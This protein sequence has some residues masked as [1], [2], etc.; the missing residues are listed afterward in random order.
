MRDV[1]PARSSLVKKLLFVGSAAGV[2]A[3]IHYGLG[4]Q[5]L[6]AIGLLAGLAVA[7]WLG[8]RAFNRW[9]FRRML[10]S[11]RPDEVLQAWHDALST[12]PNADT[13]VPLLQATAL[14]A[15]GLTERAREALARAERG[16]AW[17]SAYEHRLMIETLLDS[18]EGER[19]LAVSK[20]EELRALP[21]PEVTSD[22]RERITLLRESV[23][24]VA[25]AF[26]HAAE[27][28]DA[29]LLWEAARRNAL[30]HWPLRYAAAVVCID[31]GMPEEAARLLDGAPTWPEESAFRS[32]HAELSALLE[33][34]TRG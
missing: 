7:V 24:A 26:A 10:Q 28:R 1:P 17:R 3:A 29:T 32:F 23:A 30:I 9:R 20:G 4:K 22:L 21:L 11:G 15:S 14:A 25:R 12:M 33:S 18:F 19:A 8:A 2:A 5:A 31:R 34:S 27:P 16:E 13:T 6:L